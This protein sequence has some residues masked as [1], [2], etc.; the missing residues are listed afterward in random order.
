MSWKK[1]KDVYNQ[2]IQSI[3][4]RCDQAGDFHDNEEKIIG[5]AKYQVTEFV[6]RLTVKNLTLVHVYLVYMSEL[7]PDPLFPTYRYTGGDR[8]IS[9]TRYL[10]KYIELELAKQ[11]A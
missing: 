9:V 1:G 5:Y 6:E 10:I 8:I 2:L 11:Y 7:K 3:V 4:Q